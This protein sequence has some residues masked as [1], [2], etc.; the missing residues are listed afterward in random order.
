MCPDTAIAIRYTAGADVLH[1][2]ALARCTICIAGATDVAL[3][4]GATIEPRAAAGLSGQTLNADFIRRVTDARG[5]QLGALGVR[6]AC[7]CPDATAARAGRVSGVP[8]ESSGRPSAACTGPICST[9][10]SPKG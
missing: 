6:S 10:K 3:L 8:R 7:S 4:V 9:S 1:R 5:L 2:I